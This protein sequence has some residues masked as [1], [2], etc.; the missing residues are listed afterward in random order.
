[1]LQQVQSNNFVTEWCCLFYQMQICCTAHVDKF[2]HS[3]SIFIN[4]ALD[5]ILGWIVS[6]TQSYSTSTR[7]IKKKSE[8]ELTA[9]VLKKDPKRTRD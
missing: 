6:D 3:N 8:T 5:G 2:I 1:M 9:S 7:Q 4:E